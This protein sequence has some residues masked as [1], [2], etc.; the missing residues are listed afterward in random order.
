M[1]RRPKALRPVKPRRT[2]L[3][4]RR[5]RL[6]DPARRLGTG[7]A[8][9]GL[10]LALMGVRLIQV[11]GVQAH[12][13]A[14]VAESER[15]RTVD[16]RAERG[17]ITDR[18][19]QV[20]ARSV[21]SRTVTAD[22]TLVSDPAMYAHLL[23]PLLGVDEPT[24]TARLGDRPRRYVV[25]ARE[26]DPLVWRKVED[27]IDPG[28]G[29]RIQGLFAEVTTKRVYPADELAAN[30]LGFLDN[31]GAGMGG[32]ER[33]FDRLLSGTPGKLTYE[34][35]SRGN[36]IATAGD[37]QVAPQTGQDLQLTI[38]RDI[39][40]TAQEAIAAKVKETKSVSGTVVVMNVH[41]GEILAM[42]TAPTFDPNDPG[43]GVDENRGNRVLSQVYEPGSIAKVMTMAAL[44]EQGV[45]D[46]GTRLN[47]PGELHRA[48]KVLHD[49][50]PHGI[51]RLTLAGVLAQSS[52]V[53]TVLA[54][55]RINSDILWRY[56]TA[57]GVGQATGLGFPGESRGILKPPHKWSGSQR[58]TVPFGQGF[59]VNSVQIANI[60]ATLANG[61]VRVTPQLIKSW[62]DASGRRHVPAPGPTSRVVSART[63]AEV[64]QMMEQVL[65]KGGTAYNKANVPDYAVAGKTGTAQFAD[66]A[67]RCYRGYTASFAGF[68]PADAPQ[69][70]VSATL[71]Q[72]VNGH[73]GGALGGPVFVKTMAF[74]LQALGIRPT[75][76]APAR[77]PITW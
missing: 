64:T 57:F 53:G 54:A 58:Y 55:D 27:T 17:M 32:V 67:C 38:D 56:L 12:S 28:T 65:A 7:A 20:L 36:R 71:Q 37:R 15:L 42:A 47:V 66:P 2:P 44:L 69:I 6:G 68:A 60:Y 62:V 13:Y 24:L 48:G 77:I 59:A 46:P 74:A 22:P 19:G 16:I 76:V 70:V 51:E 14:M 35:D 63:A 23:S 45:A 21:E 25:L 3:R 1:T 49:D 43:K 34:R 73:F 40:W 39:Q 11:Q 9:L 50:V 29:K 26:I 18:D 4:L 5:A 33:Q 61:G 10:V 52:N 72:P 31:A 41:T 75:G 8:L 30:I